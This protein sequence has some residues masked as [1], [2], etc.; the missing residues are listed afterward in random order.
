MDATAL[1][2]LQQALE[3]LDSLEMLAEA[4][5]AMEN[6]VFY[7]N[8]TARETMERFHNTLNSAL[9]GADV[10]NALHRSI[11]QFHKDPERIRA[12]LRRLAD[13]SLERHV[14]E[15]RLGK[16]T[17]ALT[18]VAVRDPSGQVIAFH[19]SW[20]DISASIEAREISDQL[21]KVVSTLSRA[22]GD[23]GQSMNSVDTAIGN[24]GR[25]IQ[26]N[27]TAV[28]QLQE[29]VGAISTIV[30]NIREISYQ[31]NL[32]ALNA[33]IE[34]A[35]AGE[36][37]RGFA[38]VA[39]EVR[40]LARRVQAATAEVESNTSSIGQQ[41]H[42]IAV[43]SAS[44]SKELEQV[45]S[46]VVRMNN[47]VR[48]MQSSAMRMM[49]QAAQEEHNDFVNHI[50]T[51]ASKDKQAKLPSEISDHHTCRLGKWYD[52]QGQATLGGL[53]AFRA[54]EAPHAQIHTTAKQLLEAVHAG[55]RDQVARL[56]TS[57]SE[58][59]VLFI[60]RLQALSDAIE[61]KGNAG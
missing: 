61:A 30:R 33:A 18:F 9:R 7:M 50:L 41:A 37:G 47:Q 49:L 51:E 59:E 32:L 11:H 57:L 6:R 22:A 4:D 3:P 44:S 26:G 23:I 19:A 48:N 24:V 1:H 46:V 21:K 43:T 28:A 40:N 38:V 54:L 2:Y 52:S 34:A 5:A 31:T 45:Q 20:R 8:R 35:R 60:D 10:R 16:V 27:G 53:S 39:D 55:L 36:H 15:M 58:Q 13:G 12:I 29:Q 17:F 56:S 25:A 42:D 14:Q